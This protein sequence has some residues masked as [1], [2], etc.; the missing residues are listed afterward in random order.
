MFEINEEQAKAIADAVVTHW[1]SNMQSG[2]GDTVFGEGLPYLYT[3]LGPQQPLLR[4][5]FS[6]DGEV[7]TVRDNTVTREPR[8]PSPPPEPPD[9]LDPPLC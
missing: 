5:E 4:H 2:W 9:A 1:G 6:L 3:R 7:H 8:R